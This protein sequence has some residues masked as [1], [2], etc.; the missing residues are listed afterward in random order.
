MCVNEQVAMATAA[1]A[2][3]QNAKVALKK[4]IVGALIPTSRGGAGGG[5]GLLPP[6]IQLVYEYAVYSLRT[7]KTRHTLSLVLM[8]FPRAPPLCAHS[9]FGGDVLCCA[10]GVGGWV[11]VVQS[12]MRYCSPVMADPLTATESVPTPHHLNIRVRCVSHWMVVRF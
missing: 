8:F 1:A 4:A 7:S 5:S 12:R 3:T 2:T 9:I 10:G 6:L 11:G